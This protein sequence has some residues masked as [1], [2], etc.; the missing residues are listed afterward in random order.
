MLLILERTWKQMF[1]HDV[2]EFTHCMVKDVVVLL[3]QKIAL[4]DEM[5][6]FASKTMN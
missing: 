6:S 4:C 2:Y 1:E 5:E 3:D